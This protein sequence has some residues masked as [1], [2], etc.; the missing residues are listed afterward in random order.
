MIKRAQLRFICIVMSIL[1][2]MFAIIFGISFMVLRDFH[3]RAIERTL[4]DSKN[5][6]LDSKDNAVQHKSIIAIITK[7]ADGSYY[8]E[9]VFF[10]DKQFSES[11]ANY[12]I[13]SALSHPHVSGS[14]DGIYYKILHTDAEHL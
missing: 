5:N 14:I 9:K 11:V 4:E 13:S 8:V 7:N 3:E 12:V 2:G 1:L 6:F 10:D